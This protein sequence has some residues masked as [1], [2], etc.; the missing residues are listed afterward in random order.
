MQNFTLHPEYNN[1][2]DLAILEL[3]DTVLFTTKIKPACVQ[4]ANFSLDYSQNNVSFAGFGLGYFNADG[5]KFE[6]EKS[7]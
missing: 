4:W 6:G 2:T 3:E 5:I 7:E 1:G